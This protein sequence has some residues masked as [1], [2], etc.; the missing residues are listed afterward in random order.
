M[1]NETLILGLG[2]PLRGDDG[3][4]PAVIAW[5][6]EHGLPTGVVA[7]DGGTAGLE[8]VLTLMGYQRA[9]IVDAA[10]VG[11]APGEWIRFTPDLQPVLDQAVGQLEE[12]GPL[13]SLHTAGLAEA[14]ALG[15][16]LGVLPEEVVIFGVQPARL[17]WSPGLSAEVQAA[18][19]V[20]GREMLRYAQNG[21]NLSP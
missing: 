1:S 7:V 4:G 19:P 10:E 15:A 12:K 18:V 16:A 21:T 20:V 14:L 11:R 13:L 6:Q 17:D 5:L 3:L 2:N 9:L 8:L